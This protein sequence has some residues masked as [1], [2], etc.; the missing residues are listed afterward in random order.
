MES[1]LRA[2]IRAIAEA[3]LGDTAGCHQLDHSVRGVGNALRLAG[4]CPGVDMTALEAA[5]AG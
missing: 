4:R 1:S 5:V 2:R 3:C